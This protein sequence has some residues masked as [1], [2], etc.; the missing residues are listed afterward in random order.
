MDE[1]P[2]PIAAWLQWLDNLEKRQVGLLR[3]I[4]IWTD[5]FVG[6]LYISIERGNVAV[7]AELCFCN[8]GAW[9]RNSSQ[10]QRIEESLQE[11]IDFLNSALDNAPNE[12]RLDGGD[13][14]SLANGARTGSMLLLKLGG[15]SESTSSGPCK[16]RPY[17]RLFAMLDAAG[18][19]STDG[20][21]S[22]LALSAQSS[23]KE[24]RV[25]AKK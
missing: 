3:T 22:M 5:F 18:V 2:G 20:L 24:R 23:R 25:G 10:G 6:K 21:S 14:D 9:L 7:K 12:T 17:E 4:H 19:P 15:Y 13:F 1:Y 16:W 11:E 8:E